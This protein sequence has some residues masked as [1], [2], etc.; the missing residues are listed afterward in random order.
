MGV[1][2]TITQLLVTIEFLKEKKVI[3]TDEDM[4]RE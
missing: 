2:P 1:I 4:T 3:K